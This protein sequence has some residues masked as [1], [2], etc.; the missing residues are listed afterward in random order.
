MTERIIIVIMEVLIKTR[1]I[2]TAIMMT[3]R[4]NSM[5]KWNKKLKHGKKKKKLARTVNWS[6][7]KPTN[8]IYC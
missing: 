2:L 1:I 5:E 6:E 3:Y 4:R 8:I 7:K